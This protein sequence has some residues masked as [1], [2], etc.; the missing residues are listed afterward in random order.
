M[1][2]RSPQGDSEAHS[3]C[4]VAKCKVRRHLNLILMIIVPCAQPTGPADLSASSMGDS[5]IHSDTLVSSQEPRASSTPAETRGML[6]SE[7]INVA[8]LPTIPKSEANT[9]ARVNNYH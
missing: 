9:M 1:D 4:L 8:Y 5:I 3:N 2:L 6:S 7:G